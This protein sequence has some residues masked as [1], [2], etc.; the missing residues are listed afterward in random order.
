M[1]REV[2]AVIG[3]DDVVLRWSSGTEA[4]VPDDR[5]LWD[6]LWTHRA[7]LRGV[8]HSHPG[9]GAPAPSPEDLS[10][11]AAV[12]A[13]LGR[14]LTWWIA[15]ADQLGAWARTDSGDYAPVEPG[16]APWLD[17]VRARSRA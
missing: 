6:C 10:T 12:E 3:A 14:R 15:T 1:T 11:F 5:G 17:A 8:A 16:P 2:V 9:A 7:T 13:G 4:A